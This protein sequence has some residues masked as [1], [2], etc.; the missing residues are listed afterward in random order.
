MRSTN[1]SRR[2]GGSRRVFLKSAG[3]DMKSISGLILWL[4][5]DQGVTL[6]G[7]SVS[8]WRDISGN[9]KV[10]AQG[11]SA[12]QPVYTSI[13]ALFKSKPTIDFATNKIV[14]STTTYAGGFSDINI[15]IVYSHSASGMAQVIL[16][17]TSNATT[18]PKA[19][20][21]HA[22]AGLQQ[23]ILVS[24]STG[25]NFDQERCNAVDVINTPYRKLYTL[26]FSS[27]A[28]SAPLIYEKNVLQ[29][30]TTVSSLG[31]NTTMGTSTIYIGARSGIAQPFSGSIAEIFMFNRNLTSSEMSLVDNY[32]KDRYF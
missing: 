23:R 17:H 21:L 24:G 5:A 13:N 14:N 4:R 1:L 31:T 10:F 16:E 15:G 25:G 29:A 20:N 30:T 32:L 11:T 26:P 6:S 7:P 12:N 8:E 18:N 28:T 22:T 19:F 3:F 27:L 9:G 2:A